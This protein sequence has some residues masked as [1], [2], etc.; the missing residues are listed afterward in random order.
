MRRSDVEWMRS[1][2]FE[3]LLLNEIQENEFSG[4]GI[5]AIHKKATQLSKSFP[6]LEFRIVSSRESA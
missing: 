6:D 5:N 3:L 1:A 2:A 4:R